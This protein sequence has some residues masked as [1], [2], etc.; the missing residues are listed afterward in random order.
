MLKSEGV[1][2]WFH[3]EYKKIMENNFKYKDNESP[4]NYVVN[5]S[6][7]MIVSHIINYLCTL[8]FVI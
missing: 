7:D 6:S 4:L 8:L 5:L 2:K 1:Q 3:D